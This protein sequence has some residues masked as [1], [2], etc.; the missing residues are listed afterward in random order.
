MMSPRYREERVASCALYFEHIGAR[1]H[2]EG[3]SQMGWVGRVMTGAVAAVAAFM[4]LPVLLPLGMYQLVKKRS[5]TPGLGFMPL[6]P[7]DT[8]SELASLAQVTG[9]TLVDRQGTPGL[10][11]VDPRF[12]LRP[13]AESDPMSGLLTG[14]TSFD[15]AVFLMTHIPYD[16]DPSRGPLLVVRDGQVKRYRQWSGG[17][18][19][20]LDLLSRLTHDCRQQVVRHLAT[21]GVGDGVL[22]GDSPQKDA[23]LDLCSFF[24][25]SPVDSLESRLLAILSTDPN[26]QV[27]RVIVDRWLMAIHQASSPMLSMSVVE[28]IHNVLD[29]DDA[30]LDE[31]TALQVLE[32]PHSVGIIA[33][34]HW[35]GVKGG[36]SCRASVARLAQSPGVDSLIRARCRDVLRLLEQRHGEIQTGGISLPEEEQLGGTLAVVDGAAGRLMEAKQA[37]TSV[38]Q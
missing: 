36:A 30:R 17:P 23:W 34:L 19:V 14:D 38:P 31:A 24:G 2:G 9:L 10:L 32:E 3:E 26:V 21:G 37:V 29:V 11:G 7:T 1:E 20:E 16:W 12:V 18:I 28:V 8:T 33:A 15:E 5:D 6:T 35:L 27:K 4:L 25:E 22:Y 13:R